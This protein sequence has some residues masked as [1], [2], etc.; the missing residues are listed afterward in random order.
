MLVIITGLFSCKKEDFS[1]IYDNPQYAIGTLHSYMSIPLKVTYYYT[2]DVDSIEYDG[3]VVAKG[4]GQLDERIIGQSF[5]VVYQMTNV[6]NNTMNFNYPISSQEEFDSLLVVF[7]T[8]PP[9][10]D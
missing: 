2:F 7:Q 6:E 1:D 4:I 9:E 8:N 10:Q 5:L 3:K